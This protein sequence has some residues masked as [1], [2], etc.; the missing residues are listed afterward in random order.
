LNAQPQIGIERW[1]LQSIE[2][3]GPLNARV[4]SVKQRRRQLA[5]TA[6]VMARLL[7][8][9]VGASVDLASLEEEGLDAKAWM[10][11]T[12]VACRHTLGSV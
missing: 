2:T 11:A 10:K 7:S 6:R 5:E 9:R 4:R 3:V 12:D 8:R 1:R